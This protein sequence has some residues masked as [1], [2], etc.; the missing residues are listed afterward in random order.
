[1]TRDN[2]R[3]CLGHCAKCFA[4]IT[5][6]GCGETGCG[7]GLLGMLGEPDPLPPLLGKQGHS[8]AFVCAPPRRAQGGAAE[9]RG[10]DKQRT[11]PLGT[12]WIGQCR[13]GWGDGRRGILQGPRGVQS[14]LRGALHPT[15]LGLLCT[16]HRLRMLGVSTTDS[17]LGPG[18]DPPHPGRKSSSW[19]GPWSPRLPGSFLICSD[20]HNYFLLN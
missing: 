7:P 15:C 6:P 17:A 4:L 9:G 5:S 18:Q 12:C 3:H 8:E 14:S 2:D 10:S 1:M 16:P 19:P 11:R 20:D 13:A